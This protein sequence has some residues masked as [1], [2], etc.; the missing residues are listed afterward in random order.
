[1][2][3]RG[4]PDS[5]QIVS[6]SHRP[7]LVKPH[8]HTRRYFN[9][10]PALPVLPETMLQVDLLLS[11]PTLDLAAIVEAISGDVGATLQVLRAA[12]GGAMYPVRQDIHTGDCVVQLGRKG[13][14]RALSRM[15]PSGTASTSGEIRQFWQQAEIAAELSRLLAKS[16]PQIQLEE[17]HMAGLLHRM[18][19]LPMILGW[20]VEGIDLADSI[21]VGRAMAA[22][23]GVPLV[24]ASTL[25][26]SDNVGSSAAALNRIVTAAWNT[27]TVISATQPRTLERATAV[28]GSRICQKP[29]LPQPQRQGHELFRVR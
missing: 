28:S 18:G 13:L 16:F 7:F 10:Q 14:R 9:H 23:W 2:F 15:L 27:A 1:M 24:V 26:S 8:P 5:A 20:V 3:P 25:H 19:R 12:A 29:C 22:E 21:T 4:V 6:V 11:Q 17:A